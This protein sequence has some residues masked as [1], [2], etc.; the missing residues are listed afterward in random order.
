M[1]SSRI[2][3]QLL[4]SCPN[5]CDCAG[6]IHVYSFDYP[7]DWT[8]DQHSSEHC[9]EMEAEGWHSLP[10]CVFLINKCTPRHSKIQFPHGYGKLVEV[11]QPF[12]FQEEFS[13]NGDSFLSWTEHR[14]WAANGTVRHVHLPTTWSV[15]PNIETGTVYSLNVIPKERHPYRDHH[16]TI[17]VT[18]H[19][20]LIHL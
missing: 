16:V 14:V 12:L 3:Q 13:T 10:K 7:N 15:P 9:E 11:Q 8:G 1:C 18:S 6:S 5:D 2:F 20:R 17:H 19:V 4:I